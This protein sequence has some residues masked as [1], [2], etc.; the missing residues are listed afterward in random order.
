MGRRAA[1]HRDVS[2]GCTRPCSVVPRSW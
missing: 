2:A 1:G